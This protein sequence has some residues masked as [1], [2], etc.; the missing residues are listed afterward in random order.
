MGSDMIGPGFRDGGIVPKISCV[1]LVYPGK[2]EA[3]KYQVFFQLIVIQLLIIMA[4]PM[5]RWQQKF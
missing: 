3:I 5:T 2:C 1:L 4:V